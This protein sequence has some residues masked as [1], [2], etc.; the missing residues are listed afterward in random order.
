[1]RTKP[2]CRWLSSI[3]SAADSHIHRSLLDHAMHDNKAIMKEGDRKLPVVENTLSIILVLSM[4][5]SEPWFFSTATAS[6]EWHPSNPTTLR[7]SFGKLSYR[8]TSASS[9]FGR[10]RELRSEFRLFGHAREHRRLNYRAPSTGAQATHTEVRTSKPNNKQPTTN[11]L[12]S[13]LE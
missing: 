12:F 2:R 11:N 7:Q 3:A 6:W 4:T 8:S 9:G 1:M 5:E 13:T 10:E